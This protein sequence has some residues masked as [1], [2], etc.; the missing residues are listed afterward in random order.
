MDPGQNY[1]YNLTPK[2]QGMYNQMVRNA[3]SENHLGNYDDAC[4]EKYIRQVSKQ[5]NK[6][7]FLN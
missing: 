5:L 4:S 1:S 7:Y 2:Y 3:I 6:K